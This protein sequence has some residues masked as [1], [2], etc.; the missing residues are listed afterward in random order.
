MATGTGKTLTSTAIMRMFLIIYKV[1]RILFLVDRLELED[2]AKKDIN[3][4]LSNDYQTVIWKENKSDWNTAEIVISTGQSFTTKNKYKR[5]FNHNDFDL[6]IADEVHRSL[7]KKS[8]KVFEYFN[9]FKLGLTAT[10]KNYLRSIDQEKLGQKDPRQLEKRLILDTYTTFGCENGEPTFKYS[11]ED[12]VKDGYLINPKVLDARTDITTELL[13][14]NGYYFEGEDEEGNEISNIFTKKDFEKKFFSKKT[15]FIFCETFLKKAKRD[16]F[17]GEV[18]KTII[19]C[20]SQNHATKVTQILN[21][22]ADKIFPHK[23]QSDFAVQVTSEID[24]SQNMTIQ[25]S[26]RNNNLN[27]QS[28]FNPFYKTS[29]T[30]VCVTVGMMTT[31]YDCKDLLNICLL[32]PISS[33]SEFVQMKGRGT[34]KNDFSIHWIAK[35]EQPEIPDKEKEDFYLFDFFGNYEYFEKDFDYDEVLK[36]SQNPSTIGGGGSII[37][38]EDV[39]IDIPDPIQFYKEIQ[40]G[41]EGMKIDR[42]L[43][44]SFKNKIKNNKNL[45]QMMDNFEY[46]SAEKYLNENIFN[47]PEEFFT[48]EKLG[49]ALKIDRKLSVSELLLYAFDHIHQIKSRRE[50]LDEE[51]EKLDDKLSPPEEHYNDVKH[52]FETYIQDEE[53][54][55]IIDNGKFVELNV[56]PSGQCFKRIPKKF[57]EIIPNYV[58]DRINLDIFARA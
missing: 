43:Y 42:E 45:I 34:R 30:R 50:C 2:Q 27:G 35:E 7:G 11:L 16:P 20:V 10:P 39:I 12:G 38:D 33:P 52:F 23:Y 54:R 6:V 29:K 18:G 51:F 55:T 53:Y 13:S 5:I 4:I 48:L 15:N 25:F 22:L 37:D 21:Q 58:R 3:E 44:P 36:L 57:R 24:D 49:K 56:H 26:D 14:D 9:G 31:G 28:N 32:R 8:R 1:K 40:I 47:K 41:H 46:E 17:T 19:F